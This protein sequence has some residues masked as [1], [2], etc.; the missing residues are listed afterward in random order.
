MAQAESG[1]LLSSAPRPT[2]VKPVKTMTSM[3]VRPLLSAPT[4][5]AK[6]PPAQ[7]AA[8]P[9]VWM[10]ITCLLLGISGG[11]RFWRDWQFRVR[12]EQG[13]VCPFPLDELPKSLGG[14]QW[15]ESSESQLEPEVARTAG[16]SVNFVREYVNEKGGDRISVMVLYGLAATVFAHPPDVCYP[17]HGY[18]VILPPE[19]RPLAIPGLKVPAVCRRAIYSRKVGPTERY[20]VVYHTFY[21]DGQWVPELGSRWK[22]FRYHPGAFKIQ[23]QREISGTLTHEDGPCESL[24]SQLIQEIQRRLSPNPGGAADAAAPVQAA[25]VPAGNR[26][27]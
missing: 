9:W 21:H 1:P 23:L 13:A 24:L 4:R 17:G 7:T 26:G 18:R 5:D 6:P 3:S 22:A 19:D 25:P 15:I 16:S 14:W 27:R 20:Q 12:A 2:S 8:S 10:V 11:I